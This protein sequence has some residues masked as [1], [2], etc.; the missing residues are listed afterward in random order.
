M[1]EKA[2][3][4]KL[5][6]ALKRERQSRK[7]AERIIEQKALELYLANEQLKEI[8]KNQEQVIEDRTRDIERQKEELIISK[9]IAEDATKAKSDFLSNMTHELRTPLN[10]VI[11]LTELAL[12]EEISDPV[13]ELIEN[14]VFSAHHL[15]EVINEILDF[16]KIEAGKTTFEKIW[17]NF[18]ELINSTHKNLS[19]VARKK[20][21]EFKLQLN[22]DIPETLKGDPVKLNQILNNLIGN[23]VKFTERGFVKLTCS[24]KIIDEKKVTVEFIIKDT[25]VGI[26]EDKIN[27]IFDSFN[28]SDSSISR[29]FGGTGLGLTITKNF[30]ELQG[31]SINVK[32]VYGIGTVFTFE[33]SFEYDKKRKITAI[34]KNAIKN[35]KVNAKILVVDDVSMNQFV[36]SKILKIWGVDVDLASSAREAFILVKKEKYDLILM[37]VQM[38]EMSGLE[39]TKIIR[40]SEDYSNIAD[41]PIV[42]FTASAFEDTIKSVKD[43]GMN[44]Y[45]TKPVQTEKLFHEIA[46]FLPED[47]IIST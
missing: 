25:G 20:G 46:K 21:L 29:K 36:V 47:K 11:G 16:S 45:V 34:T 37:D 17:F 41:I 40:N 15:S 8:N 44:S 14:I 26:K 35:K 22:E 1:I 33:L 39:A 13:R 43:A 24:Q 18:P 6:K 4:D 30:V 10:G 2:K 28:Q 27:S 5:Y 23:S 7:E 12:N 38:P 9:K 32:S 31:G 42:A 19:L 3:Y